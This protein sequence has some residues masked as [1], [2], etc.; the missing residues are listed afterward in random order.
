QVSSFDELNLEVA[1][2]REQSKDPFFLSTLLYK[3]AKEREET[4]KLLSGINE[5]YDKIMFELKTGKMDKT[6]VLQSM[7]DKFEMLPEQDQLILNY[8]EEGGSGSAKEIK[9]VMRYKGLNAASQR[10]NK[11][12]KEGYLKKVQSGKQVLYLVKG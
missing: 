4:N 6:E 5:K 7:E 12:Y 11:L 3:L 1:E 9:D 8:I 10:L 2:I